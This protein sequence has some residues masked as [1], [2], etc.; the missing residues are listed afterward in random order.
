M[1]T[2]D[3]ELIYLGVRQGMS[4]AGQP[5]Q[6]LIVA[7]PAKYENFEYFIGDGIQLPALELNEK[8][9]ITLQMTKR[10]FNNVPQLMG[11]NKWTEAKQQQHQKA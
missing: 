3:T 7:D 4:K 9:V 8:V 5:Y 6:V 11:V 2:N 1:F 10:G